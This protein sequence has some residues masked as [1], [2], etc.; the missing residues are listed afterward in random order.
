MASFTFLTYEDCTRK[1]V[2]YKKLLSNLW[3]TNDNA[4]RVSLIL[5][6]LGIMFSLI[7]LTTRGLGLEAVITLI[8]DAVIVY[9]LTQINVK[10]FFGKA[11]LPFT[12]RYLNPLHNHDQ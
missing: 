10:G 7:G 6:G 4:W 5:A 11:Q 12:R 9:Y 1:Q 3:K 2:H 8:L